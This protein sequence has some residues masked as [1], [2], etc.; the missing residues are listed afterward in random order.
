M[1]RKVSG[2]ER[3]REKER[4]FIHCLLLKWSQ[5]LGLG[6]GE[7]RSLEFHTGFWCSWEGPRSISRELDQKQ[8][9]QD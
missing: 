5:W 7:A 3:A 9:S 1:K 2:G 4:I 6:Q 8:S